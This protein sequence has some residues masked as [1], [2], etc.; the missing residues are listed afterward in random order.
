[1]TPPGD[2]VREVLAFAALA[3]APGPGED[4]GIPFGYECT[5]CKARGVHAPECRPPRGLRLI[6]EPGVNEGKRP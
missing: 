5:G 3:A 6:R 4:P 2:K 1:V